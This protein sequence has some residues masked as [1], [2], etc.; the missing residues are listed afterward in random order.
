[1]YIWKEIVKQ[2]KLQYITLLKN[3]QSILKIIPH[4]ALGAHSDIKR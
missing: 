4:C 1:M 3:S 2:T